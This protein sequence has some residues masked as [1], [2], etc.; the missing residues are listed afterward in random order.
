MI[1]APRFSSGILSCCQSLELLQCTG[2]PD[3]E[4]TIGGWH[5]QDQVA[6]MD[7]RHKLVQSWS[8]QNGVEQAAYLY[9]VEED[10]LHVEVLCCPVCYWE[11]DTTTWHN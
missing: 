7:Y 4:D 8:A 11:G 10:A 9:D 3:L 2:P 5:L 6:I 1:L